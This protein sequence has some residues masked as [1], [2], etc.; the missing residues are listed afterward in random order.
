LGEKLLPAMTKLAEIATTVATWIAE[1]SDLVSSLAITLGILAGGV[2]AATGVMTVLNI[3]MAANPAGAVILGIT[4]LIAVIALLAMNWD[5]VVAFLRGSWEGFTKWWSDG[6]RR[7][8]DQ[9]NGF[10]GDVGRNAQGAWD[11]T[12]G[13][14]LNTI[15]DVIMNKVPGA[16]AEGIKWIDYHW[17][18]I[19]EIAKAPVRFLV[20]TVINDG[21]I[22]TFNTVAGWV[23]IGKL[24]RVG[25]PAGFAGGGYTGEGAKYEPAG[26]VHRGE[27][28][29]TKEQTEKAG[30]TA[31]SKLAASLSGY[32]DG[33]FVNPVPSARLSQGF[34]SGHNGLDLAAPTGT[35][36][37]AAFGGRVTFAQWSP[38]GGGNEIHVQHA[39]GWETWYAHL[40]NFLTRSGDSVNRG[41]RIGLVGSTG[42]STGP[43]LH[44][45]VLKG[46]WPNVVDPSP[47]MGGKMP[48]GMVNPLAGIIDGLVGSLAGAFPAGQIA[49]EL[50]VGF[51]KKLLNEVSGVVGK[52]LGFGSTG[53]PQL[54][55]DGGWMSSV[56]INQT[57]RP[58][59]VFT[60]RQW[61]ILE[62][63]MNKPVDLD[64]MTVR[65]NA[66]ATM[67][68]F[69]RIADNAVS[70]A[71]DDI[72][73]GRAR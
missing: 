73:R 29:F 37:Q 64:G 60:D 16:F 21:L 4:A 36:V 26:V 7:V 20:D 34:W 49:A 22:G 32:A 11:S 38:Y 47:F 18:R 63:N 12:I 33:G 10:W 67:L 62:A 19:R 30:V 48:D 43:H 53:G 13:P 39:G 35:P 51:G 72:A 27:F 23:G 44:Y 61:A 55:D 25:L 58:E 56:G 69:E 57:G 50:A 41:Q 65:L 71:N 70:A 28:V 59:A 40:S 6:M 3:V 66:D 54:F 31:L 45:M 42:N 8:G 46:G 2:V 9:W 68:T 17:S 24:G 52:S 14:V 15:R 5:K 1:N